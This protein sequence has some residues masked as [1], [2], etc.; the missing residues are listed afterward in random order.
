[1][2]ERKIINDLIAEMRQF[3]DD[4]G[5]DLKTLSKRATG[6][7]DFFNRLVGGGDATTSVVIRVRNHMETNRPDIPAEV[8]A[9]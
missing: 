2:H 9:A 8:N 1:M 6:N 7:A 3:S 4:T 5:V